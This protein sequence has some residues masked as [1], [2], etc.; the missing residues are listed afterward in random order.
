MTTASADAHA[1]I[2]MILLE[3]H[4]QHRLKVFALRRQVQ[5]AT[6]ELLKILLLL[7]IIM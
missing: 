6:A 7:I 3:L 1:E 2:A 4:Q 5:Q